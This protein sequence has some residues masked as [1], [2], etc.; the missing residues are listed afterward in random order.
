[1]ED[2]DEEE[3]EAEHARQLLATTLDAHLDAL[4]HS[5]DAEFAA[6]AFR[7]KQAKAAA[8]TVPVLSAGGGAGAKLSKAHAPTLAALV[9]ALRWAVRAYPAEAQAR[10]SAAQAAAAKAGAF[11]SGWQVVTGSS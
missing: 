2:E 6:A 9:T 10:R 8:R 5:P 11:L 1:V 4:A 7:D 3:A